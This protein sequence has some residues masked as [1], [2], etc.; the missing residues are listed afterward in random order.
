MQVNRICGETSIPAEV[1]QKQKSLAGLVVAVDSR[2]HIHVHHIPL[3]RALLPLFSRRRYFARLRLQDCIRLQLDKAEL[4]AGQLPVVRNFPECEGQEQPRYGR[5]RASRKPADEIVDKTAAD[6][7][8]TFLLGR[9]IVFSPVE[10]G[11][12]VIRAHVRVRSLWGVDDI[13]EYLVARGLATTNHK[14][15]SPQ[16]PVNTA[17][18]I[19]SWEAQRAYYRLQELEKGAVSQRAGMWASPQMQQPHLRFRM[20]VPCSKFSRVLEHWR[21]FMPKFWPR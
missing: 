10:A 13:A 8:R 9:K 12:G 14:S 3:F 4:I 7:L 6:V 17:T 16:R 20:S 18:I 21:M 1:F 5:V 15:F 2:G 19:R 11:I